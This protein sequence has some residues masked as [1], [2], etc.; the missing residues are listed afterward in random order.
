MAFKPTLW[1]PIAIVLT[2]IN[3]AGAGFA[4]ASTEPWHA[5]I[6]TGLALAFGLWAQRLRRGRD[7]TGDD[8][9]ID[10]TE[11]AERLDSLQADVTRLRQELTETQERLDFL[12]RMLA[13]R[14][15]PGQVG[16]P[17]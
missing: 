1:Y 16:P 3:L 8:A 6:H 12:E 10:G 2:A 15:D 9:R 7:R 4:A 13:Q 11:N 17:R 14:R 5:T